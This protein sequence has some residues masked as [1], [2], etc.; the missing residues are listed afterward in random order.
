MQPALSGAL[1][2]AAAEHSVHGKK[3]LKS[4]NRCLRTAAGFGGMGRWKSEEPEKGR[5]R[6]GT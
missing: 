3:K 4:G 1:S 6:D 2:K 5:I